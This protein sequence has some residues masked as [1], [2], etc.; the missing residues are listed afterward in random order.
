MK[1]IPLTRLTDA[2]RKFAEDNLSLVHSWL[3]LHHY[4]VD[5]Y[6]DI[7]VF[8]YLRSVQIWHSRPELH[9]YAFSTIA[10]MYMKS[11]LSLNRSIAK[12]KKRTA[13]GMMIYLDHP[14]VY[15]D[16]TE[17]DVSETIA[18][19]TINIENEIMEMETLEWMIR[20]IESNLSP[21]DCQYLRAIIKYNGFMPDIA[22]EFGVSM[23]RVH[24]RVKRIRIATAYALEL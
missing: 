5:Q 4:D 18:D 2:E 15:D 6:Y 7:A 23:Q 3:H 19:E 13:P 16:S 9:K 24:Q 12:A 1:K 21:S 11:E 20:K 8:G 10:Y 17:R 22:K 14:C